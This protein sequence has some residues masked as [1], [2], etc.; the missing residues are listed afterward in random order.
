[1]LFTTRKKLSGYPSTFSA[2]T[3]QSEVFEEFSDPVES[4]DVSPDGTRLAVLTGDKKLKIYDLRN[5]KLLAENNIQDNS[6]EEK[7]KN[8]DKIKFVA[9]SSGLGNSANLTDKAL[10]KD[11]NSL[12]VFVTNGEEK[13]SDQNIIAKSFELNNLTGI[14]EIKATMANSNDK[15]SARF[16]VISPDNQTVVFNDK[17]KPYI[18]LSSSN[19]Y[20]S[21]AEN[22]SEADGNTLKYGDGARD[23]DRNCT[24]ISTSK[25]DVLAVAQIDDTIDFYDLNSL[26]LIED[27]S[28]TADKPISTIAMNPQGDLILTGHDPDVGRAAYWLGNPN[29]SPLAG[30]GIRKKIVFDDST[31]NMSFTLET[32]RE[33]TEDAFFC[34]NN[35]ANDWDDTYKNPLTSDDP[36]NRRD[37]NLS[38]SWNRLDMIGMPNG[39]AMVLYGK[40]DGS[41]M[42]EWIGRRNW[43]DSSKLGKYRLFARWTSIN[44]ASGGSHTLP[45]TNFD[46]CG[47][48][49]DSWTGRVAI[50]KN[51]DLPVGGK[52]VSINAKSG[53]WSPVNGNDNNRSIMPVLVEKI[54]DSSFNVIDIGDPI[55]FTHNNPQTKTENITWKND[56][57]IKNSN[58]RLGFYNGSKFPSGSPAP[59]PNAGVIVFSES[60]SD[61]TYIADYFVTGDGKSDTSISP[62]DIYSCNIEL[63]EYPDAI[64]DAATRARRYAVSFNISVPIHQFPPLYSQKLAL[65]P[66][67]GTLAILSGENGNTSDRNKIATINL[68]DFHNHIYGHDTQIEGLLVDYR[69]PFDSVAWDPNEPKASGGKG[70]IVNPIY[71][72]PD[73]SVN[74]FEAVQPNCAFFQRSG[75]DTVFLKLKTAS[76]KYDSW[77]IFNQYPGNYYIGSHPTEEPNMSKDPSS[78]RFFGYY[79]PNKDV[80]YMQTYGSEDIRFFLNQKI[81]GGR[82]DVIGGSTPFEPAMD[83]NVKQ[84]ESVLFQKDE[85]S[86]VGGMRSQ[87]YISDNLVN[88]VDVATNSQAVVA[89]ST[90]PDYSE[91]FYVIKEGFENLFDYLRSENTYILNNHPTFMGSFVAQTGSGDS[92]TTLNIS[93]TSMI[94]SRD[95]A[96]PVLYVTGKNYLWALY[97]CSLFRTTQSD[98]SDIKTNLAISTDGQKLVYGKT[99]SS[100]TDVLSVFDISQPD[101]TGSENF[102]NNTFTISEKNASSFKNAYLSKIID[103]Q[104]AST[105]KFLAAKPFNSF[106]SAGTGG[107]YKTLVSGV[108]FK[109]STNAIAVASGGIYIAN[110]DSNEIALFNPLSN[111]N[112]IQ[113]LPDKL[114][115]NANSAA[116][117]AYDDTVYLFGN[118]G[119]GTDQLSGRV[120]S[121]NVNSKV[122]MT[123]LLDSGFTPEYNDEYQVNMALINKDGDNFSNVSDYIFENKTAVGDVTID[124]NIINYPK[125]KYVFYNNSDY[126]WRNDYRYDS[127]LYIGY[128][129]TTYP[130]TVN[131]IRIS[132]YKYSTVLDSWDNI[133]VNKYELYG[134]T[135]TS[136]PST[137]LVTD[138]ISSK[139]D[140]NYSNIYSKEFTNTTPYNYY[141]LVPKT[142]FNGDIDRGSSALDSNPAVVNLLQLW[143][144]NVRRLTPPVNSIPAGLYHEEISSYTWI[145][146]DTGVRT[147]ITMSSHGSHTSAFDFWVSGKESVNNNIINGNETWRNVATDTYPYLLVTLSNPEALCA[148]RYANYTKSDDYLKKFKIYASN[149]G[150]KPEADEN[151]ETTWTALQF[152]NGNTEF[153][154]PLVEKTFI[155]AEVNNNKKYSKYLFRV[156]AKAGNLALG[157]FE[158]FSKP[159]DGPEPPSSDYLSALKN[160]D[161][162]EVKAGLSAAC[163]TP[164]GIFVTGGRNPGAHGTNTCDHAMLY[165]PHAINKYDGKFTQYGIPRSLPNMKTSRMQ[166]AMVWHKGRIYAIGGKDSDNARKEDNFA[167]YFDYETLSDWTKI[168]KEEFLPD[169]NTTVEQLKRFNHGA[170]SYGEEIFIF[171]GENENGKLKNAFA[172][173]PDSGKVRQINFPDVELSPCSAVVYG[174]KI[175]IIGMGSDNKMKI[176][177]YAP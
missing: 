153:V 124:I 98:N 118:A 138:T 95:R 157:G 45:Y 17:K 35:D 152:T 75:T 67:T 143:R 136:F 107:D 4:I 121:Y 129:T 164:Y 79:R 108:N 53:S 170:C 165:W 15:T 6:G 91:S 18:Y 149:N 120:Q 85:A 82:T 119:Q 19:T 72:W 20:D 47:H 60:R 23:H 56:G 161:F 57:I 139:D 77:K 24:D 150:L 89:T 50:M 12:R 88:F 160:D 36:Y 168:K 145:N 34:L 87:V 32:P 101:R 10:I 46:S 39:G 51:V 175:Y 21:S 114:K 31:P 154:G 38:V 134:S 140:E 66:D 13:K 122:S 70:T 92:K 99:N 111:R 55:T 76:S 112:N 1:M 74:F 78:K 123:S 37:F 3:W 102:S 7:F 158:L 131:K 147:V 65:S 151:W 94:F 69:V 8:P 93:N 115:K 63:K 14:K 103:L 117:A 26:T 80:K 2:S 156:T 142:T 172:W 33:S 59:S 5:H 116:V 54:S 29:K 128:K 61:Y 90:P 110:A 44:G 177:E 135:S 64:N 159:V 40:T 132:N 83:F 28:Y 73:E 62:Y 126:Y 96:K 105:P 176:Y 43:G 86:N 97:N 41:S 68:Y 30:S 167:E 25:R 81:I 146:L 174:S 133:G 127:D 109:I 42:L 100:G 166:H 144:T 173:N 49:L 71:N 27:E 155:T 125:G 113:V 148:V 52:V 162:E 130:V 84:Y 104:V 137:P 16:A 48:T 169:R 163:A 171:G 58:Y 106:S 11:P 141:K 9:N 22:L